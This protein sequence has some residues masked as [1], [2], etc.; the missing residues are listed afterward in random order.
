MD[1]ELRVGDRYRHYKGHTYELLALGRYE[2]TQEEVVIYQDLER[3]HS[4]W[5]RP[6]S[7]FLEIVD[8][9]GEQTPRFAKI[10]I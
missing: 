4:V 8:V 1:M 10:D 5:V 3:D 9:D 6:R 2:P 7:V